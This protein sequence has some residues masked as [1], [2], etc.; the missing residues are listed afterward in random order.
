MSWYWWIVLLIVM[1]GLG[2]AGAKYFEK[3]HPPDRRTGERRSGRDRRADARAAAARRAA[4]HGDDAHP[5]RR[6]SDA[7]PAEP[8][9][10]AVLPLRLPLR[11]RHAMVDPPA[12]GRRR[13]DRR[14]PK[15]VWQLSVI[16]GSVALLTVVGVVSYAESQ[17]ES[18]FTESRPE[19]TGSGWA[20]CEVPITWSLD[21]TRLT[22]AE[23]KVAVE[24]LTGDFAKWGA[25]SGLTFEYVGEVP[26][27]YNDTNFVVTSEQH[28]SD[29]H[30]Y[31]AF[32][33]DS[34]SSLLDARTVGF[35]SPSKVF[36]NS[37][38]IVEGSV[39]LQIE[40]VQKVNKLHSSSLYLHELGHALGLGHGEDDVTVMYPIV[41]TTNE[42]SPA[43]IAGIRALTKVC[44]P[45]S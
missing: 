16:V 11:A 25:A 26:V 13:G 21:T 44:E 38:Q 34:D 35:A 5:R 14:K 20:D 15:P 9:T 23:T 3:T 17:V 41:D 45:S 1:Y 28:P 27:V 6:A 18:I 36:V 31:V 10:K 40:Y 4:T 8:P 24:Q 19:L 32:L 7:A 39:V 30:L 29:R 37:R 33:H 22:P 42:L 12:G 43:D 2:M